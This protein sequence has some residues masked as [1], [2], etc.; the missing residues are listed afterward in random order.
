MVARF[1]S[2]A[3][4]AASGDETTGWVQ[5]WALFLLEWFGSRLIMEGS[6]Y[7]MPFMIGRESSPKHL[8]DPVHISQRSTMTAFHFL[9]FPALPSGEIH[10]IG[11]RHPIRQPSQ[12]HAQTN[13]DALEHVLSFWN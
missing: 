2:V 6:H 7:F 5:S 9:Q 8:V 4:M 3:S 1:A 10:C 11:M 12:S 13:V